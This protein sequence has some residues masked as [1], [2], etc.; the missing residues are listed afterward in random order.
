MEESSKLDIDKQVIYWRDGA[1]ETWKDVEYNIN[2]E[3]I[4]FAMFAAHLVIEKALK[5]HVV[6]KDQETCT[7]NTQLVFTGKYSRSKIK[8][9]ADAIAW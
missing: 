2:G 7:H 1:V 5:A 8:L 6:K 9:T 4:A 3:R